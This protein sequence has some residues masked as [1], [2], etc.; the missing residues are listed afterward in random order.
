MKKKALELAKYY[1]CTASYSGKDKTMYI[2]GDNYKEC[3]IAI[4]ALNPSFDVKES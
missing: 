4:K 2:H 1:G 3:I